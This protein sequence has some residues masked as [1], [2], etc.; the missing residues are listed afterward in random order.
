MST[1]LAVRYHF[2]LTGWPSTFSP[3]GEVVYGIPERSD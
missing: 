2:G 1:S 3:E